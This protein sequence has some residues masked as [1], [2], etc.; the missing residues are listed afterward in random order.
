MQGFSSYFACN[1]NELY[2]FLPVVERKRIDLLEPFDEFEEFYLKCSHYTLMCANKGNCQNVLEKFP[3][4]H[5]SYSSDSVVG[6]LEM[7][8]IALS[9]D[10]TPLKR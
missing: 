6:D 8:F 7:H 3:Q 5:P 10:S 1:M 9:K 2:N 4:A